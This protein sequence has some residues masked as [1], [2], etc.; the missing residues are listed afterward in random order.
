LIWAYQLSQIISRVLSTSPHSPRFRFRDG[1]NE[2]SF[3]KDI[4]SQLSK[5]ISVSNE[6]MMRNYYFSDNVCFHILKSEKYVEAESCYKSLIA[7]L[8]DSNLYK[9]SKLILT[10]MAISMF[11]QN[12]YELAM[13]TLLESNRLDPIDP[14]TNYLIGSIK[15]IKKK[16]L[17]A[18]NHFKSCLHDE[19][20][21][22]VVYLLCLYGSA[23]ASWNKTEIW[24]N[25]LKYID[26]H[27]FLLKKREVRVIN[28]LAEQRVLILFE[29]NGENS[30]I[31]DI[32]THIL[33]RKKNE[34]KLLRLLR[35]TPDMTLHLGP[36]YAD[37]DL[38]FANR[39]ISKMLSNVKYGKADY[40]FLPWIFRSEYHKEKLFFSYIYQTK[41][42]L[43]L[44][45]KM[46]LVKLTY[47]KS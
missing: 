43:K 36:P 31:P 44:L 34:I 47:P 2:N 22:N 18:Q 17:S 23:Y 15:I 14:Y 37:N 35:R 16:E 28:K 32:Y 13:E 27:I 46:R 11:Y 45:K 25:V 26:N 30:W 9:Y 4:F 21:N 8:T 39:M 10:N 7:K 3:D 20:K 38:N 24:L 42:K 6:N 12:K 29:T 19:R 40:F 1:N 33:K 5:S 41:E